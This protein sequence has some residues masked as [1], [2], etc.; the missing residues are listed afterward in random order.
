[1]DDDLY[2]FEIGVVFFNSVSFIVIMILGGGWEWGGGNLYVKGVR[3]L[4]EVGKERL[5]FGFCKGVEIFYYYDVYYEF[6]GLL[7]VEWEF[8]RNYLS[9]GKF[10]LCCY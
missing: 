9:S 6:W 7:R 1:M 5:G 2:V 4:W 3:C 10:R 8:R